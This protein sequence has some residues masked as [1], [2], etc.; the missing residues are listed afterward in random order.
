MPAAPDPRVKVL[1]EMFVQRYQNRRW[2]SGVC[3]W[4]DEDQDNGVDALIVGDGS[5]AIEHTLVEPFLGNRTEIERLRRWFKPIE[6]DEAL[7]QEGV[8]SYVYI[9]RPA[10]A[11]PARCQRLAGSLRLWLR[12]VL[13]GVKVNGQRY[14]F[15]CDCGPSLGSFL[16]EIR[17]VALNSGRSAVR[18]LRLANVDLPGVLSRSLERKVAKL[19]ATGATTCILLLERES[20][21]F[22]EEDVVAELRRQRVQWPELGNVDEVW[23]VETTYDAAPA[24]PLTPAVTIFSLHDSEGRLVNSLEFVNGEFS[25]ES[26]NGMWVWDHAAES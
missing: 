8:A 3:R 23:I 16:V 25:A 6:G 7:H 14:R 15:T 20:W 18:V 19:L 21:A 5:L 22:S 2:A 24:T 4:P 10:L 1:V 12:G 26:R 11:T 9:D 17:R 13:P